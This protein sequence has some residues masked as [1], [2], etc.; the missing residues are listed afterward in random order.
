MYL[1][2]LGAVGLVERAY[3]ARFG[4]PASFINRIISFQKDSNVASRINES[5]NY[6]LIPRTISFFHV[7]IFNNIMPNV[8]V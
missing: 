6:I 5:G 4:S 8:T 1:K 3:T 2:P 7:Y